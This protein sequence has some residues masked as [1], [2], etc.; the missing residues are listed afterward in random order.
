MKY[1]YLY[2]AL[3]FA[4]KTLIAQTPTTPA[5]ELKSK[6][7]SYLLYLPD[8]YK[9]ENSK[10]WPLIIYLHGKSACGSNLDKVRRYGMPF[11]LDRGLKLEAI[12][13]APQCPA[14]KNWV[15][16]NWFLPFLNDLKEKYSIDESR[17]YLTGMSLGGFGTFSLAIKYPEVFAAAVPLC[18]GGQPTTA[19]PMKDIPT[20]VIHGDRDE[21]V[22][23]ARSTQMVEALKKCGGNPR[24]TILKGQPHDIHRTYGNTDIYEWMLKQHKGESIATE[25]EAVT[26]VVVR[27]TPPQPVK[28][29]LFSLKRKAKKKEKHKKKDEPIEES[30]KIRVEFK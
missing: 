17:I 20:W 24:F 12:A 29:K 7:Y 19:C 30:E 4:V 22:P 25:T 11:Y 14:G 27:D 16:D 9:E 5:Q 6:T 18:G 8:N 26:E 1:C 10:K 23:L 21:Q 3:L 15:A 13:I 2:I 28:P